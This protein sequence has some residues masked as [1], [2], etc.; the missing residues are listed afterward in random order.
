[1]KSYNNIYPIMVDEET[2]KAAIHKT[3]LGRKKKANLKYYI[4][5]PEKTLS[6]SYDWIAHYRNSKHTPIEIYD[7]ISR[8]K[9]T[10]IVPTFQELVVQHAVVTALKPMLYTGMYEHSYASIPKR[11]SHLGKNV[12]KKWIRK[13]PKHTQY[14]LKMDIRHFFDSIPHDILKAKLKKK[15]RDEKAL[16]IIFKIID[17]TEQGLPLGF[18][19]SQWFSNWY[20][21]E[22]DHY[23]KEDL[24]ATHYI[25][26]MDDMVILDADK[27][28]LHEIRKNI[29]K[30]LEDKLGLTLKSNWQVYKFDYIKNGKHYGRDIDFMGFRFFRDK[31][32]MRRSVMLKA[33]RKARRIGKKEKP[34]VYEL[35]QMLS[36]NGWVKATDT[37][38]MYF[39]WIKPYIDIKQAKYRIALFDY[40]QNGKDV[41]KKKKQ[42]KR[43]HWARKWRKQKLRK[44]FLAALK[45]KGEQKKI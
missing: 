11:G 1:M 32:I 42:I 38:N 14:V 34:S 33:T 27:T 7:G 41:E 17:V 8:K 13:D 37:Y 28:K 20:L 9:R 25:R 16:N 10:I 5:N 39:Q 40:R 26:Y 4:E 31:I 3:L 35:R 15:I 45:Q 22:L 43:K 12:M 23:I 2:R 30:Y 6:M 24:Q 36:Y 44:K 29:Q 18:F 19:T 21:Q